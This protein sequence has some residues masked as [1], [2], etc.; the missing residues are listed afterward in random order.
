MSKP[1]PTG[2]KI[3]FVT[4]SPVDEPPIDNAREHT[5]IREA[6][7]SKYSLVTWLAARPED[8]VLAIQ[9]ERPAV[10]HFSG[11]GTGKD[12]LV[13]QQE[14]GVSTLFTREA[15]DALLAAEELMSPVQLIV[16]NACFTIEQAEVIS[17][18]GPDSI[19][20]KRDVLDEVAVAF[21]G[22][23]YRALFDNLTPKGALPAAIAAMTAQGLPEADTPVFFPGQ[24]RTIEEGITRIIEL[25]KTDP[26]VKQ[27]IEGSDKE[28][29]ALHAVL[30]EFHICKQLH[31]QLHQVQL[32]FPNAAKAARGDLFDDDVFNT[33][34]LSLSVM[35]KAL[36]DA[37]SGVDRIPQAFAALAARE[38]TSL[39]ILQGHVGQARSAKQDSKMASDACAKIGAHLKKNL[40]RINSLLTENAEAMNLGRL[41][42]LFR[43][44]G[45]IRAVP[46]VNRKLFQ[47]EQRACA[48]VSAALSQHISL[49]DQWQR[50]DVQLW[51]AENALLQAANGD[52]ELFREQWQ[53]IKSGLQ[54]L[55]AADP[56][57]P[58]AAQIRSGLEAIQPL[59]AANLWA[60][61]I[62]KFERLARDIR[63][64]FLEVD[65]GLKE[66]A[67]KI[68][69][70]GKPLAPFIKPAASAD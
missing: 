25:M 47:A 69:E 53:D 42:D 52:V 50:V 27:K 54:K 12:G 49:H 58:W 41:E 5:A 13:F 65:K 61:V 48:A 43:N 22:R 33:F 46:P 44:I 26:E 35:E 18:R 19:V 10:V 66:R 55:I 23:Y 57:S 51:A 70:L 56:D 7:L 29:R 31:D 30:S 24:I 21:S 32:Q 40:P 20:M 17:E 28:L 37:V 64:Q 60:S 1:L 36:E 34:D 63:K 68:S 6:I 39:R 8:L 4:A 3:L 15:M 38:A 16:L 62:G 59:I 45:A 2:S 9:R 14:N 11:H 67:G